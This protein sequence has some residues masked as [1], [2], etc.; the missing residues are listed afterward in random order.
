MTSFATPSSEAWQ[1]VALPE[2][3]LCVFEEAVPMLN[4]H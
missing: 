3:D 1:E 4:R 2:L